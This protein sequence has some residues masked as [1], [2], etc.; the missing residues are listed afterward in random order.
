MD[1]WPPN[2][3]VGI[4]DMLCQP[5]GIMLNSTAEP[6]GGLTEQWTSRCQTTMAGSVVRDA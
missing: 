5:N 2:G 1:R 6:A 4:C 3:H